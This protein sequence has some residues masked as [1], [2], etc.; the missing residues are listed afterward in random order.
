LKIRFFRKG[1]EKNSDTMTLTCTIL[2]SCFHPSSLLIP[3]GALHQQPTET[4]TQSASKSALFKVRM[5]PTW[6]FLLQQWCP[7]QIRSPTGDIGSYVYLFDETGCTPV[8]FK[9]INKR[10]TFDVGTSTA[11]CG[12]NGILYFSQMDADGGTARFPNNKAGAKYRAGYWD[13]DCPQ[14]GKF[15]QNNANFNRKYGD[16]CF[17]WFVWKANASPTEVAAHTCSVSDGFGGSKLMN[18]LLMHCLQYLA[19]NEKLF[20]CLDTVNLLA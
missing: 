7:P 3:S 14:D 5:T 19:L 1:I 13:A 17:E 9:L 4:P 20:E 15:V 6:S 11:S 8:N 16:S 12:V 2:F 18:K 10:F